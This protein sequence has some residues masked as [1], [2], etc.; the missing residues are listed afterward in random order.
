MEK[1]KSKML[2]YYKLHEEFP[3]YSNNFRFSSKSS[4]EMLDRSV[5]TFDGF[6]FQYGA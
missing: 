1:A 6:P 2:R 4:Q 5:S 3:E